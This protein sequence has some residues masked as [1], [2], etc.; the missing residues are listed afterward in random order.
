MGCLGRILYAVIIGLFAITFGLDLVVIG[1]AGTL[2]E[3][4][5]VSADDLLLL[6]FLN[7][8][9]FIGLVILVLLMWRGHRLRQRQE[10]SIVELRTQLSSALPR[11]TPNPP[12][13]PIASSPQP[14]AGPPVR[15]CSNCGA[16][17]DAA[18]SFCA[19]CGEPILAADAHM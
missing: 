12:A 3:A 5:I 8:A 17:V 13:Q 9:S 1:S 15:F 10:K 18:N 11:P 2:G 16:S 6:F 14:S 7:A 4:A 19:K